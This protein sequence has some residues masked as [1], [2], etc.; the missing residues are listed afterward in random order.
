MTTRILTTLVV[1]TIRLVLLFF[2]VGHWAES[3]V[4]AQIILPFDWNNPSGGSYSNQFNWTS[5][6]GAFLTLPQSWLV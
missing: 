6:F 1:A 3:T 5:V 4:Q 2:F